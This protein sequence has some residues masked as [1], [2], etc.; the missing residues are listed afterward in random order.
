MSEIQQGEIVLDV[1]CS[2]GYLAK[3]IPNNDVW[4]IDANCQALFKAK[5]TCAEVKL[6]DLNNLPINPIFSQKFDVI[7][8]GDVLEHL[9]YPDKVLKHFKQYL[10]S[11]GR[12]IVSLPNIALWRVRLNLLLG[13]FDYSDYGVMDSTHLHFYT[14][15]TSKDLISSSGYNVIKVQGAA[16]FLGSVVHNASFLRKILSIHIIIVAIPK[17]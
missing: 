16:N 9:L 2:E 6:V 15:K 11:Q 17:I 5:E 12:I 1:G 13:K 8:F 7:V 3:H 14:F 10:K 4:G